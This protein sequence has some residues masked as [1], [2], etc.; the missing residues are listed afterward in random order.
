MMRVAPSFESEGRAIMTQ[1]VRIQG[2]Q[3]SERLKTGDKTVR[4]GKCVFPDA[5]IRT[6]WTDRPKQDQAA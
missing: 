2:L 4:P 1:Q 3:Q 5:V 6:P